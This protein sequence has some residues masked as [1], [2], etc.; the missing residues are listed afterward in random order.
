MDIFG[1]VFQRWLTILTGS[2]NDRGRELICFETTDI[3]SE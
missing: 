3:R 1:V 2:D